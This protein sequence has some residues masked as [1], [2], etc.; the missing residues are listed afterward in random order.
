MEKLWAAVEAALQTSL[1]HHTHACSL[2]FLLSTAHRMLKHDFGYHPYKLHIVQELKETYFARKKDFCDQ[3][4]N[5]LKD[6]ELL[7][8]RH[9]L[10]WM[11]V[12][13]N[14]TRATGRLIIQT[15]R[16]QNHCIVNGLQCSVP[17]RSTA[18]WDFFFCR[19]KMDTLLALIP[20][21]MKKC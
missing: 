20:Y 16:L 2:H 6:I 4:C 10:N 19:T 11:G 21:N 18:S 13:T 1:H 12:W 9:N 7:L 15:G 5:Y 14:K 8:A 3:F 17:F